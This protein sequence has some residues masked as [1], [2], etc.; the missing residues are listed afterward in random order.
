MA[1]P[2]CSS[3]DTSFEGGELSSLGSNVPDEGTG[4]EEGDRFDFSAI[5]ELFAVY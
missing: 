5:E 1:G 3:V 4:D 2:A